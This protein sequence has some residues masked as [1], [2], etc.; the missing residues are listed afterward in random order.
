MSNDNALHD[1]QL[2]AHKLKH[3]LDHGADRL[4][5]LTLNKLMLARQHALSHQRVAVTALSLAGAGHFVQGT[6]MPRARVMLA[7]L[8]LTTGVLGTYYWNELQQTEENEEID[9]ALLAD[10]LPI[11]AYLNHGFHTWLEQ[12]TSA[13]SS[14]QE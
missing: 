12:P 6:L 11:N 13:A 14:L 5:A 1:E 4:N 9:S 2:F 8:A 7:L 10:D 3:H